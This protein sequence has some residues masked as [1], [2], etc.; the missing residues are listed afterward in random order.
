MGRV[1]K[2]TKL[3]QTQDFG[4]LRLLPRVFQKIAESTGIIDI[5]RKCSIEM[6][7]STS[8]LIKVTLLLIILK[9]RELS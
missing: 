5:T 2:T 8:F 9:L 7:E 1:V 6:N 3:L 4:F